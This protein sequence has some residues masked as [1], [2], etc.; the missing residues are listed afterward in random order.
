[1]QRLSRVERLSSRLLSATSLNLI[2][3][4]GQDGCNGIE[5]YAELE[6]GRCIELCGNCTHWSMSA[7]A[8]ATVNGV[9]KLTFQG[10]G[11][12]ENVTVTTSATCTV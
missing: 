3:L 12:S 2:R 8:K 5:N 7:L 9:V 10:R 6:L 4:W 11:M 1:M